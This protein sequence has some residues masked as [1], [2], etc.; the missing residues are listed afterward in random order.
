MTL[1]V[2]PGIMDITPYVAGKSK[3]D[4]KQQQ[5]IIK[6]S[7]NENALGASPKAIEAY[8]SANQSLHRYPDSGATALREAIADIYKLDE[9]RI[10]CGCG[11][12]ELIGLLCRAYAGPGNEVLQTEHGFL[13]YG[14]YA[15]SVGADIIEAPETNLKTD[16]DAIIAKVTDKTSIVFVANPNNPTGS[17]IPTSE[18]KRLREALADN[19]LLVIDAAYAEYVNEDNYDAGISLVDTYDNVAMTRTFSKIYGLPSLRLGW[20]YASKNIT[21]ILNR[22]RGPFNVTGPAQIAGVTAIR[23]TVFTE[24]SRNHN[25][26]QLQYLTQAINKLGLE[27]L[28]SVGNFIL[29]RFPKGETHAHATYKALQQQG[30]IVRSVVNY[31]LPDC[32]RITVGTTEENQKLI[33]ALIT[34]E[35]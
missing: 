35:K 24:K 10:V 26:E 3:I 27:A 4:G 13:M 21:N 31:K 8:N 25:K 17:Y 9:N 28:P 22:V 6:L 15:K 32:L 18:L 16:V 33:Q 19:I 14:I 20:C 23:D 7:S 5:E 11:S 1:T 12:D 2:K 34:H 29:V 30:I